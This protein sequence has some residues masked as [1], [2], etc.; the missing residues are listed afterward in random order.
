MDV[1]R[2]SSTFSPAGADLMRH[3]SAEDLDAAQ[4]LVES[5]RGDRQ[6]TLATNGQRDQQPYAE[7]NMTTG[8][9]PNT[10]QTAESDHS[11]APMMDDSNGL[12]QICR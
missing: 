7:T 6:G 4:Q 8:R 3:P 10:G 1:L 9:T 11:N 2:H 12:G 5:A